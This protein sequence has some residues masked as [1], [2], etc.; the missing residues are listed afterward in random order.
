M[1][2]TRFSIERPVGITMIILFF[3]V[4]G[5]FSL[6]RIGVEL[7]PALNS[8]YV[9]VS[10]TYTGAGPKEIEQQVRVPA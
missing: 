6:H 3:V 5:L 2:I 9:T 8:P 1:N 7:L 10:V 4:L